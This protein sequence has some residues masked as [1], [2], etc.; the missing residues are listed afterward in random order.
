MINTLR[1]HLN[2]LDDNAV[3]FWVCLTE[4][5]S[6][7]NNTKIYLSRYDKTDPKVDDHHAYK[8]ETC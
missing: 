6:I 2:T 3:K 4:I 7:G 8:A 5:N 1:S